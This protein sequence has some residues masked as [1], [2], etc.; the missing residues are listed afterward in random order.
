MSVHRIMRFVGPHLLSSIVRSFIY[1]LRQLPLRG[2]Y[3]FEPARGYKPRRA[4]DA[5]CSDGSITRTGPAKDQVVNLRC[6]R[7]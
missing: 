2:Y 3:D 7:S 6:W 1:E 4:K 5:P